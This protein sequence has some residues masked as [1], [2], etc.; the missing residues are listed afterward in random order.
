M[1][2]KHEYLQPN[3]G[4]GSAMKASP[5]GESL[6]QFKANERVLPTAFKSPFDTADSRDLL[7]LVGMFG[8]KRV[9]I[10]QRLQN[11]SQ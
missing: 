10:H 5:M 1:S 2:V 4:I 7:Q 3:T 9:F 6:K 11:I 8:R